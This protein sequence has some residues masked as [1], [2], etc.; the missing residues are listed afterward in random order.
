MG[1]SKSAVEKEKN[2]C[3]LSTQKVKGQ[4]DCDALS[5]STEQEKKGRRN[6]CSGWKQED[7]GHVNVLNEVL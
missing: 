2:D 4:K 3:D 6:E 5:K 7:K 1:G